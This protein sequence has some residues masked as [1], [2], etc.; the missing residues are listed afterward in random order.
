[1]FSAKIFVRVCVLA[2][3][4]LASLG[5]RTSDAA[6]HERVAAGPPTGTGNWR[7]IFDDEF[8]GTALK[9]AYWQTCDFAQI[10]NGCRGGA[11]SELSWHQPDDVLV[12]NGLLRLRAQQRTVFDSQGGQH[13][14]TSGFLTT[15]QRFN[16]KYGYM[17]TRV[18]LPK[19]RAMWPAAFTLPV[20]RRD[21][22]PEIDMFEVLGTD[23]TK[24][25]LTYHFPDVAPPNHQTQFEYIEPNDLANAFHTFGV[26]WDPGLLVYYVDGVERWRTTDRITDEHAQFVCALA[27]ALTGTETDFST[28]PA[29]SRPSLMSNTSRSGSAAI[30]FRAQSPTMPMTSTRSSLSRKHRFGIA[31]T[32]PN[33]KATPHA[34]PPRTTTLTLSSGMLA[35]RAIFKPRRSSSR[36]NR[37]APIASLHRAI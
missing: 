17:E 25:Y 3:C 14:L 26:L 33:L 8:D 11:P 35:A 2:M 24:A 22:N 1:M 20:R 30:R 19:G 21:H 15:K 36:Q 27:S 18:K 9:T 31:I 5:V 13:D 4:V 34:G 32:Q 12:Q 7:I 37:R 10:G 29:S 23:T 16:F 28:A 6:R